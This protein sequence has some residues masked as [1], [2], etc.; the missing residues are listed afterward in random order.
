MAETTDFNNYKIDKVI[1]ENR[2][3]TQIAGTPEYFNKYSIIYENVENRLLGILKVYTVTH[4]RNYFFKLIEYYS[5]FAD[6]IFKIYD[7]IMSQI[8]L[9]LFINY[10]GL[11]KLVNNI[12]E[13]EGHDLNKFA[14]MK[15]KILNN[16]TIKENL[17]DAELGQYLA[18]SLTL[19]KYLY[20]M[21]RKTFK[22]FQEEVTSG[23]TK[24]ATIFVYMVN[25]LNDIN[26]KINKKEV[27]KGI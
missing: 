21:F 5:Y 10:P 17:S 27:K 2:I 26:Q 18:D 24:N 13:I 1:E 25:E 3:N 16:R 7:E 12:Y 19:N 8:D 23:N 9:G 14:K 4:D 6:S 15:E 22:E 20:D 11:S